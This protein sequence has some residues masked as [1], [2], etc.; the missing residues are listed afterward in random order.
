MFGALAGKLL[1]EERRPVLLNHSISENE[2][3]SW[4]KKK[5]KKKGKEKKVKKERDIFSCQTSFPHM[6]ILQY[7]KLHF[8]SIIFEGRELNSPY[9]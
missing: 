8:A 3:I 6:N 1:V 9:H 7:R 2:I 5:K 4:R